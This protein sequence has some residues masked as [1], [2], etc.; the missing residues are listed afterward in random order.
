MEK[1]FY[2]TE[3]RAKKDGNKRT[4]TGYAA[5]YNVLSSP[6]QTG[7]GSTFRERIASGA[8][9]R[10]LATNPDTVCTFNHDMNKVLGRTTSGTLRLKEDSRG[11]AF[12]CDVPDTQA[13]SDTYESVSRGDINACSFAFTVDDARMCDYREEEFDPEFD[14]DNEGIRGNAKRMLRAIVRTIKDFAALI[15]VSAVTHPAYPQTS[16]D[17]RNLLVGAEVRSRVQAFKPAPPPV[18]VSEP[19]R[20]DQTEAVVRRRRQNLLNELL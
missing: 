10:I 5:R 7:D 1:R 14:E 15:D 3:V 6:L 4:I 17:A 13:G 16:L 12:E 9:K 19:S 2:A 20:D 11:L 18:R 8:F